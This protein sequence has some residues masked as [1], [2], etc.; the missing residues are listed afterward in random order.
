[1]QVSDGSHYIRVV[2][3]AEALQAEE[4]W[5]PS[6]LGRGWDCSSAKLLVGLPPGLVSGCVKLNQ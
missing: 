2:I 4:K 3:T 6:W 5:V 1:M